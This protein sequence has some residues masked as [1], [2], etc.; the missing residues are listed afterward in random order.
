MPRKN[1]R[2]AQPQNTGNS[3]KKLIVNEISGFLDVAKI[4]ADLNERSRDKYTERSFIG[5]IYSKKT[6][7]RS[8]VI[9]ITGE[10]FFNLELKKDTEYTGYKVYIPELF[11]IYPNMSE[12]EIRFYNDVMNKR[13][14]KKV[15]NE[16]I[17]LSK[18]DWLD[19]ADDAQKNK[20]KVIEKRMSRF[21]W[22]FSAGQSEQNNFPSYCEVMVYDYNTPIYYGKF[23]ET[24]EIN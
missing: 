5:Q 4:A 8:Q 23:V 7:S 16:E 15:G 21:P 22:F 3:P 9:S 6:F 13:M 19:S 18:E 17:A 1:A 11:A 20:F 24:K 10:E 14:K 2:D 12:K